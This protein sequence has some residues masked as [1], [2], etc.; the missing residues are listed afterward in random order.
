MPTRL[1]RGVM[2]CV[3][4][5]KWLAEML[6]TRTNDVFA[7][8]RLNISAIKRTVMARYPTRS[9]TEMCRQRGDRGELTRLANARHPCR[10]RDRG[11][12]RRCGRTAVVTADR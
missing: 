8:K 6:L 1:M 2:F 3:S 7:L 9:V 12:R 10:D 4:V 11:E 5:L